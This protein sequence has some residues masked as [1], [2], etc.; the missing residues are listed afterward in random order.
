[1]GLRSGVY[2]VG[3]EHRVR[4]DMGDWYEHT[5]RI[6]YSARPK[7]SALVPSPSGRE[8][9]AVPWSEP[10]E[11]DAQSTPYSKGLTDASPEGRR[12]EGAREVADDQPD[13]VI[14]LVGE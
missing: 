4:K 5:M 14:Q 3:D 8:W 12:V 13:H 11:G 10:P 2:R 1:M 7:R 9:W 6:D